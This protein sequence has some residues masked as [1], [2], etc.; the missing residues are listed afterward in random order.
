MAEEDYTKR[1]LDEHPAEAIGHRLELEIRRNSRL[2]LTFSMAMIVIFGGMLWSRMTY[3]QSSFQFLFQPAGAML[4]PLRYNFTSKSYRALGSDPRRGNWSECDG[5]WSCAEGICDMWGRPD[6]SVVGWVGMG[7][8]PGVGTFWDVTISIF[9]RSWVE[10]SALGAWIGSTILGA[11]LCIVYH[12][13]KRE[14][15]KPWLLGA[16]LMT[17]LG[18]PVG[19]V[20]NMVSA[21]AYRQALI[22]WPP[23]YMMGWEWWEV[24]VVLAAYVL[25]IAVYLFV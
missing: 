6:I 20:L 11:G 1:L 4:I 22:D 24:G 25:E 14:R 7:G 21:S 17:R 15:L 23:G 16:Y 2:M 3:Q 13:I 19:F 18:I 9:S 12:L 10:G 8:C 5:V